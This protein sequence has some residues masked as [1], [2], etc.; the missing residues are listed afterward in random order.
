MFA[1][2]WKDISF[3]KLITP[4]FTLGIGK[5]FSP[6]W[7]LHFD[8]YGYSANGYR[9]HSLG[10]LEPFGPLNEVDVDHEGRF[11]Y[12]QR[13]CGVRGDFRF[14]IVNLCARNAN[15]RVYELTALVGMGYKRMI[16]YRG[17]TSKN[18]ITA[19]VGL[20]NSFRVHD[21][22][23]INLDL[24]SEIS[25]GYMNPVG[26]TYVPDM[27]VNVGLSV[28]LGKRAH[29]NPVVSV[30]M[31]VVRYRT[32]TV[33]VREVPVEG[34][35]EVIETVKAERTNMVMGSIRFHLNHTTPIANQG[36]QLLEISQFLKANPDAKVCIEGYA[37]ATS[38]S[39]KLNKRLSADRAQVVYDELVHK[40]GVDKNQL[41]MK[42]MSLDVQPYP[43]EPVWNC[44]T[45]IRLVK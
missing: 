37:D 25:D 28:Y 29:R 12:Y 6:F 21:R 4:S 30:P 23:D 41:K 7:G 17:T 2:D 35:R 26:R 1:S 40:Y 13:Y 33:L 43:G 27:A 39:E 31:E 34:K 45:L 19:H 5:M 14:N 22:L 24:I 44:V 38:G 42:A 18:L 8:V 36:Q 3:G 9:S 16:A 11:R 15:K 32:D 10:D 20:R